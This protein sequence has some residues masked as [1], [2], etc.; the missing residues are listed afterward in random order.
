MWEERGKLLRPDMIETLQGL[1]EYQKGTKL[2][3]LESKEL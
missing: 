3:G 1:R 2:L